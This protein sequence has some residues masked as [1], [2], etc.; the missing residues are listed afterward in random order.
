[1]AQF[2]PE[3]LL[4]S[5]R[6]NAIVAWLFVVFLGFVA[7]ESLLDSDF[8]WALFVLGVIALCLLVP[9]AFRDPETMLPWEVVALAA[10]PTFGQAVTP[11]LIP[12]Q[13]MVYISVAALALIVA[14]ELD[15]FTEVQMTMGFAIAF[16][17]LATLAAAGIGAVVRWR[18]DLL[19]DTTTLLKPGVSEAEI[20]D[21]LMIEFLNSALAGLVAGVIFQLYFRRTALNERL[22]GEVG[23]L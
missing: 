8:A 7:G 17:V 14:V 13:F 21:E 3:D 5:R 2:S 6:Y 20:H 4:A 9:V 10:L 18:L 12:G 11:A 16:V 22:P 19:L 15:L 23:E 1:M